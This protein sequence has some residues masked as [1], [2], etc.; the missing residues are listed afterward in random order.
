L[1]GALRH[2]DEGDR[3]I[4][5][6]RTGLTDAQLKSLDAAPLNIMTAEAEFDPI[7]REAADKII[8]LPMESLNNWRDIRLWAKAQLSRNET[9]VAIKAYQKVIEIVS[10][11]AEARLGYAVALMKRKS[12]LPLILNQLEAARESLMLSSPMD[13]RKNVY[14]SLTYVC[15]RLKKP[16]SFLK[17]L[18]YAH[19]YL[20]GPKAVKSG[21]LFM[22]IACAYGQCYEWLK[23][24][25]S[26]KVSGS[27]EITVTAPPPADLLEQEKRDKL[28]EW[29]EEQALTAMKE[30]ISR[31]EPARKVLRQLM[32]IDPRP[33]DRENDNYLEVFRDRPRF[34]DVVGASEPTPAPTGSTPS[35]S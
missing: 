4:V 19:E 13:L 14:K 30:A 24:D 32:G 16:E 3:P 17:T 34:R 35:P 25:E 11:D 8:K 5:A 31:D 6:E 20:S 27:Q 23:Q 9:D 21:S 1:I 10:N 15:L 28:L 2:A 29:I 18:N 12:A 26:H 22:N 33:A 7:A